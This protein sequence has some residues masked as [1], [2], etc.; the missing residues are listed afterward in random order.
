[1]IS[2]A[3]TRGDLQT[4]VDKLQGKPLI[5]SRDGQVTLM[6]SFAFKKTKRFLKRIFRN[7]PDLLATILSELYQS[8]DSVTTNLTRNYLKNYFYDASNPVILLWNGSTDRE[9]LIRLGFNNYLML[10]MTAYDEYNNKHFYLKLYVYD[11]KKL[12][13]TQE[14][15][16]VNKNGRFLSLSETHH[17]ICNLNHG[18][19][20]LHNPA[21]DVLLTKCIF[22]YLSNCDNNILNNIF[23]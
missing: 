3:V 22:N 19:L 17:I 6:N 8:M 15:G 18:M 11:T 10:N 5:I 2:G 16:Y 1:M 21:T 9:I 12:I 7:K 20:R 23:S 13:S 14:L 4:P